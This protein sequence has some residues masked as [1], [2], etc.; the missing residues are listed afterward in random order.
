MRIRFGTGAREFA[1]SKDLFD[2]NVN[3]VLQ[4]SNNRDRNQLEA[5]SKNQMG[6][7]R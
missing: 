3:N 4:E 6:D 5:I 2:C 7:N 1:F